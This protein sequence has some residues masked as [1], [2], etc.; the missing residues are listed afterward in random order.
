MNHFIRFSFFLLIV[1]LI[2]ACGTT[3]Q[4]LTRTP[5]AAPK[6]EFRGAWVQTVGQSRYSQM[7]SAAMK[8][9]ISDMVRKF[10]EAGVNAVIFQIRRSVPK[11]THS[12]GRSWSRGA[13][14]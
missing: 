4:S 9:Y 2:T 3:K 1:V 11:P 12:T 5:D 13:G 14:S 7:N 8:H 6:R 10:D